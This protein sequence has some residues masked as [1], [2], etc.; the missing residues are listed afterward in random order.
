VFIHA[1]HHCYIIPIGG[2][3][4]PIGGIPPPIGG[5][6]GGIGGI[7]GAFLTTFLRGAGFLLADFLGADLPPP[8]IPSIAAIDADFPAGFLI[9]VLLFAIPSA[10]GFIYPAIWIICSSR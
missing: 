4:P 1:T 5:P 10:K 2:I 9:T 7:G 3:P 8:I 6:I